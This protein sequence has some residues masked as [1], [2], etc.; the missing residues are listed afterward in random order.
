MFPDYILCN[1]GHVRIINQK[2]DLGFH[3]E[4]EIAFSKKG[5]V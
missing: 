1:N 2:C 3:E 4:N 5:L